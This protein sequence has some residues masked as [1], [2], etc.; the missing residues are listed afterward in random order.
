ML[1]IGVAVVGLCV[2]SGALLHPGYDGVD[3]GVGER[4][5]EGLGGAAGDGVDLH[6]LELAAGGGD[7]VQAVAEGFELRLATAA[8]RSRA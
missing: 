3:F 2:Q 6:E 5:D 8:R 1:I 4:R 7:F